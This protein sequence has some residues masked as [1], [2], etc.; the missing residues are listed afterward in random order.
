M[1]FQEGELFQG[2]PSH[3]IK[4]ISGIAVEEVYPAGQVIF[5]KG[6]FADALYILEEG[7]VEITID[8]KTQVS[9]SVTHPADVFGWSALVEPNKYTAAAKCTENSKVLKIDGDLLS[10]IFEKHPQEGLIVIKRLAGVIAARLMN[11]YEKIAA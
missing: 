3:I 2:I 10:R 11:A 7:G 1:F 8:G 9:F 4:E 6:D 5:K